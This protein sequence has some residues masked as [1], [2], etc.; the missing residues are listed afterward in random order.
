[1]GVVERLKKKTMRVI[2]SVLC[3]A[4]LVFSR[5]TLY[6]SNQAAAV[7]TAVTTGYLNMRE[8]PGNQLPDCADPFPPAQSLLCWMAPITPGFMCRP[9]AG[10]KGYC[11]RS[12]LKISDTVS[13]ASSA[14]TGKA[15][16]NV[17]LRSG[18]GTSYSTLTTVP[19]GTTVKVVDNSNT[20]WVYTYIY[21]A[22][23]RVT[24]A[25]SICPYRLRAVLQVGLPPVL[26]TQERHWIMCVS[27]Q[28]LPHLFHPYNRSQGDHG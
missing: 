22:V 8:G 26:P 12:Y 6:A 19:K 11:S 25:G 10:K 27:A 13:T 24:A 16:D 21:S 5:H 9:S 17:R 14:V 28:D 1:M 18:P 20:G 7:G 3:A 4:V 15:L 23:L 2:I